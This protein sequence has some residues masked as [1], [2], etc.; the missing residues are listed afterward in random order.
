MNYIE[1]YGVIGAIERLKAKYPDGE[2]D[3][4][5]LDFSND[6]DCQIIREFRRAVNGYGNE[7]EKLIQSRGFKQDVTRL[8]RNGE[9][10]VSKLAKAMR[11]SQE[12][13]M[14]FMRANP[15]VW[16]RMLKNKRQYNQVVGVKGTEKKNY[17]TVAEAARD[18][19]VPRSKMATWLGVRHWPEDHYGWRFKRLLWYELD[20]GFA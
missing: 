12:L 1:E 14:Q 2:L 9:V 10:S 7:K 20:G 13:A 16:Q 3:A 19:G 4:D 18:I 11:V 5:D 8:V 6:P 17:S 15:K